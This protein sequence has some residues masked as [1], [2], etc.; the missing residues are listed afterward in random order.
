MGV[1]GVIV[2]GIGRSL[3][4]VRLQEALGGSFIG[5]ERALAKK[6]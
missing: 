3:F 5:H 1:S 4:V 6:A 2:F